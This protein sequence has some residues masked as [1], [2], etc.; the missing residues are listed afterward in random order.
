MDDTEKLRGNKT[1]SRKKRVSLCLCQFCRR[2]SYWGLG[3]RRGYASSCWL[4]RCF[5]CRL[6]FM[7]RGHGLRTSPLL[8][9]PDKHYILFSKEGFTDNMK[10]LAEED[11]AVRLVSFDEMA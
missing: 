1:F 8:P 2:L 9:Y 6:S 3:D 4:I 5:V 11:G 10:R 7:R